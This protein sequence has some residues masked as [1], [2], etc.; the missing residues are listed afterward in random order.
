MDLIASCLEADEIYQFSDP[1]RDLIINVMG[2][3][4]GLGWH[5][6]ANEFIV[7]LMTRR[8]NTGG[9]F[10]YSPNFRAPG[11]EN[12]EAARSVLDGNKNQVRTLD[13]RVGDL[14]IFK[15]RY[16]LHRVN[17]IESGTRHTVIFGYPRPPG[18]I[19]SV[20]STMKVYGRVTPEHI[21]AEN[22]RHSDGLAD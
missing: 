6:D 4:N 14:Q 22:D 16:S 11:H 15:G 17:R 8:A 19:G 7:S 9:T 3:N 12:F 10:E 21:A 1:M 5:F 20:A 13:L 18:F 2:E